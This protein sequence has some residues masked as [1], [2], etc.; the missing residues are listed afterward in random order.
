LD[1]V[2]NHLGVARPA[3]NPWWWDVLT[4][5]PASRYAH[6]FDIDWG[7]PALLLPVLDADEAGALEQL[8]V[9]DGELRYHEHRFP[10]APGTAGGPDDPATPQQVHERQHYRLVSWRRGTAE[11]T[12]RR[13]FDVSDLAAV[14]VEDPGVFADTHGRV[15][16]LLRSD[17]TIAG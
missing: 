14:R 3:E 17:D 5:G 1:I 11:L 8:E 10:L 12:Y 9:V 7:A 4:H 2:P 15:L 16:E 6:H 13:F